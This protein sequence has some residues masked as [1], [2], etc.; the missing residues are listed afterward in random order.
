VALLAAQGLCF[1]VLVFHEAVN[2]AI[3]GVELVLSLERT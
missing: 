3:F 1:M 2:D